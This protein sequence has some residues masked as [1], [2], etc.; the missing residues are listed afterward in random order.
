MRTVSR[1]VLPGRLACGDRD[2][3][4]QVGPP[5]EFTPV[6]APAEAFL[7][8]FRAVRQGARVHAM[9]RPLSARQG[10]RVVCPSKRSSPQQRPAWQPPPSSWP[11]P[12]DQTAQPRHSAV[13]SLGCSNGCSIKSSIGCSNTRLFKAVGPRPC[14]P[15]MMCSA[16]SISSPIAP[17]RSD[18]P[19]QLWHG[20]TAVRAP[21]ARRPGANRAA[22]GVIC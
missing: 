4:R 1:Q 11:T 18:Q 3:G 10:G 5:P 21:H 9:A 2:S 20:L 6:S 14:L 16:E 22:L 7:F 15:H 13:Q 17:L 19:S 8:L 12:F